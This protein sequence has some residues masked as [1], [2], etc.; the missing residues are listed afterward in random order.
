M[1]KKPLVS[2]I[3]P[4]YNRAHLLK[5]AID[6][7]LAQTYE[8]LEVLVIDDASSDETEYVVGS[9]RDPRVRYFRHC[10][11]RGGSAARNT[12]LQLA[13]GHFVAFLDS[14][15][16][17]MPEKVERHLEVFRKH[18]E[19]DV[20]Y[21]AVRDVYP[22]GSFRIRHHDGPEGQIYDLL[23]VRNV[24][25][26]TSAFVVRRE[27]FEK[28]GGFDESLRSA[29]DYDMWLRL[30]R[31][32]KFKCIREPLVNYYWH[33]DQITSNVEA[34]KQGMLAI[35]KKYEFDLRR[36][37]PSVVADR[38][39]R[40]GRFL[41]VAGQVAEGRKYVFRALRICPWRPKYALHLLLT[42]F[43]ARP[44]LLLRSFR[45]R[46]SSETLC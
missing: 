39:F 7:A 40:L 18:P 46:T 24:V 12:G 28:V 1:V 22:D 21:S 37:H 19:Y 11:N 42:A 44:Y 4:T 32:F 38:Y 6:S 9:Y 25:G 41:V 14:D 5:R 17:W 10:T 31:H 15:D 3:I 35:L 43:G 26:P 2:V 20:V 13:R 36:T 45:R 33:G 34:K 29:Q 30:A 16:E 23:L 27:C 8:N